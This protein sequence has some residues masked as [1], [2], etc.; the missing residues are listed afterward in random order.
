MGLVP[1]HRKP[2]LIH[3]AKTNRCIKYAG[4]KNLRAAPPAAPQAVPAP[5]DHVNS[6][7]L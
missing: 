4:W 5:N 2:R 6:P 3:A 7:V 1:R